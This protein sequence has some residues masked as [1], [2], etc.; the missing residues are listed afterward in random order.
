MSK[1]IKIDKNTR[2][3]IVIANVVKHN[4]RLYYSLWEN[5]IVDG[6]YT[7]Y[8]DD[9]DIIIFKDY[10]SNDEDI[11]IVET[12][13]INNN[14]TWNFDDEIQVDYNNGIAYSDQNDVIIAECEYLGRLGFEEGDYDFDSISEEFLNVSD[15]ALPNWYDKKELEKLG[16]KLESCEFNNGWYDHNTNDDPK[17]ITT[18]LKK[19]YGENI[20]VLF[21]IDYANP[22]EMGFCVWT[23]KLED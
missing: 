18:N 4:A 14:L 19:H 13:C 11:A 7:P 17:V 20:D 21:Q 5:G 1:K 6:A 22:F 3:K 15:Q 10:A 23:R 12:Y 8:N 2:R 9:K 16:F